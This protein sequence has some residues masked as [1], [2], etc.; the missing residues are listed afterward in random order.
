MKTFTITESELKKIFDTVHACRIFT[1]PL[2][3]LK[4]W[5]EY[6]QDAANRLG[7]TQEILEK[8]IRE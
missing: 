3:Q 6:K 7:E 1:S 8:I 5:N 2:E 4:N